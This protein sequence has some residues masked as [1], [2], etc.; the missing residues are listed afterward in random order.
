MYQRNC[1]LTSNY[2][3][4]SYKKN[5]IPIKRWKITEKIYEV[6]NKIQK[7]KDWKCIREIVY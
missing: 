3:T 2:Q 7:N 6:S 4:L 5:R 1:I